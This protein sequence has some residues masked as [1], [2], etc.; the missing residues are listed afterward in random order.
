M[1]SSSGKREISWNSKS[2]KVAGISF[3]FEEVAVIRIKQQFLRQAIQ[4]LA[5]NENKKAGE[6]NIIFCSDEYLLRINREFLSHDFYT[7][8]VT[9][10]NSQ[11][12]T[13][14]GEL[15]I[16]M[17][18]VRENSVSY[19]VTFKKELARVVIHGVL[20][21]AG[22]KDKRKSEKLKMV[23]REDFYL[24]MFDIENSY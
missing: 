13:L 1:E 15:Y 20:H 19:G 16:S 18:R 11:G 8:I 4:S 17:D 12:E 9:F 6:I 10:D 21:L 5:K 22:Y 24:R 3:F 7:D 2:K 23:E 14:A